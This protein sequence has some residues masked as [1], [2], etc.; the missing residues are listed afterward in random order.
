[1]TLRRNV[2]LAIRAAAQHATLL[3][4]LS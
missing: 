2:V 4:S 1:M 3:P